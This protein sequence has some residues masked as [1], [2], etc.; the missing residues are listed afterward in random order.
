MIRHDVIW[1]KITHIFTLSKTIF[2]N[3]LQ[4]NKKNFAI[5]ASNQKSI[6]IM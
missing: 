6:K 4:T 1:D 3:L 5:I 2:N